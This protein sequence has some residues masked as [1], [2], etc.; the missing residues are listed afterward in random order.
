MLKYD[1]D[2]D[3][4]LRSLWNGVDSDSNA[5]VS[6]SSS[7]S[8]GVSSSS[9]VRS[10]SPPYTPFSL[11]YLNKNCVYDEN[12][13]RSQTINDR[14]IKYKKSRCRL[15]NYLLFPEVKEENFTTKTD[16]NNILIELI[17]KNCIID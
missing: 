16:Y 15:V 14:Q 8:S 13:L 5:I 6:S 1:L 4:R 11:E 12:V 2:Q 7:S 10:L 9:S 17:K 3:T